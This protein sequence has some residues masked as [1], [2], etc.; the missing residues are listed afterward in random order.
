MRRKMRVIAFNEWR[1]GMTCRRCLLVVGVGGI[2]LFSFWWY[3]G[4]RIGVTVL[5]FGIGVI[6]W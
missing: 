5:G 6:L 3:K 1:N 2:D 4:G